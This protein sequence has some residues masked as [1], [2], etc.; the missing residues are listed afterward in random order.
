MDNKPDLLYYYIVRIDVGGWSRV[1][2]WLATTGWLLE[3]R[4]DDDDDD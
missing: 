3:Q 2:T 4:I 1:P